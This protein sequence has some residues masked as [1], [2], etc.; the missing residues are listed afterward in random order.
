MR[1]ESLPK[2]LN[3]YQIKMM[4]ITPTMILLVL[5]NIFPLLWL[6]RLDSLRRRG[7]LASPLSSTN[8]EKAW[9]AVLSRLRT[10]RRVAS[11]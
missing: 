11:G 7:F 2:G 8:N 4:F 1:S 10:T 5:M 6:K 9:P 3:D